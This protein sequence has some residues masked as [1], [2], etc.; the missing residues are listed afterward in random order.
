MT[1]PHPTHLDTQPIPPEYLTSSADSVTPTDTLKTMLQQTNHTLITPPEPTPNPETFLNTLKTNPKIYHASMSR[2]FAADL[3]PDIE[4]TAL[5]D[6]PKTGTSKLPTTE[7]T[8]I[9]F[10][11]TATANIPNS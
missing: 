8:T 5:K 6:E 7:T 4:Q 2:Q 9:E 11:N 1:K 3:P 10:S